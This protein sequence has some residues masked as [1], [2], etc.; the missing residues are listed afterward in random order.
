V[1]DEDGAVGNN[2]YLHSFLSRSF[3]MS[4]VFCGAKEFLFHFLGQLG[5]TIC[6]SF[7]FFFFAV[8]SY[9]ISRLPIILDPSHYFPP[10]REGRRRAGGILDVE[11]RLQAILGTSKPFATPRTT[12]R[13]LF[14]YSFGFS[15]PQIIS[16]VYK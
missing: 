3:I 4:A 6:V 5:G 14:P 1:S 2:S 16:L 7:V 11:H 15:L 8:F 10:W 9:Q 12:P 13:W